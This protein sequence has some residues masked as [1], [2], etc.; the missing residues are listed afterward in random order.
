MAVPDYQS[1][2]L[3]VLRYAGQ[4]PTEAIPLKEL[5]EAMAVEF[6]LNDVDRNAL[7]PSGSQTA[8]A[9]RVGWA[10][11]YMKKAGLL[12]SPKRAYLQITELGRKALASKPKSIS[13]E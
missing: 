13:T 8:Y 6:S 12:S 3:P 11:T 1:F 7:L 4:R 10:C 2:M 5:Y 9:N